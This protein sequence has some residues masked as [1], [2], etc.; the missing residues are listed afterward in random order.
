MMNSLIFFS[1]SLSLSRLIARRSISPSH[2]WLWYLNFH[3]WSNTIFSAAVITLAWHRAITLIGSK[4]F[5]LLEC[6]SLPA[7]FAAFHLSWLFTS[8]GTAGARAPTGHMCPDLRTGVKAPQRRSIPHTTSRVVH[9]TCARLSPSPA[10]P[11]LI[12]RNERLNWQPLN[13]GEVAETQ[14]TFSEPVTC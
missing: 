14:V 6:E 11:P 3:L 1:L 4:I 10:V 13:Q 8:V 5:Y 9:T 2:S 12:C 7:L